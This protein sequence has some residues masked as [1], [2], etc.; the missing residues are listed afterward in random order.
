[1]VYEIQKMKLSQRFYFF[2]IGCSNCFYLKIA[3]LLV[4]ESDNS[5]P[6]LE[7]K[8]AYVV[9]CTVCGHNECYD[10]K[11]LAQS[12]ALKHSRQKGHV[13]VAAYAR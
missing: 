6:K 10:N 5:Q 2:F 4:M 8:C 7:A 12:E 3:N 9:A 1:M 11:L 13:A